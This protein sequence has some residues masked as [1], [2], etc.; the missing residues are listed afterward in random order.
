[1]KRVKLPMLLL[2]LLILTGCAPS[3]APKPTQAGDGAD[4][5]ETGASTIPGVAS[6]FLSLSGSAGYTGS[7]DSGFIRDS[8]AFSLN[9]IEQL[10]NDWTGAVSP[11]ALSMAL[12]MATL[13][14]DSEALSAMQT[15]MCTS[16]SA[17][18]LAKTMPLY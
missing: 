8:Y 15:A 1:M 7:V 12:Q 17:E 14:A 2:V 9:L 4:G 3:E 11:A 5:S 10:G 16:L 18:D 13:G 6:G